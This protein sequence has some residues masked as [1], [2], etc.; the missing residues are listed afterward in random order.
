ML[1][2]FGLIQGTFPMGLPISGPFEPYKK[3]GFH[4]YMRKKKKDLKSN[5]AYGAPG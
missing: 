1:T 2:V 4:I 5:I 3:H